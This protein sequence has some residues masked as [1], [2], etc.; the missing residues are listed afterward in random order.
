[1]C[2]SLNKIV[3]CFWNGK[4]A[5]EGWEKAVSLGSDTG[6]LEKPCDCRE[7]QTTRLPS[8]NKLAV[9]LLFEF[10]VWYPV[11]CFPWDCPTVA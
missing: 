7:G 10:G 1:M 4:K 6:I 11:L 8:P 5:T 9:P 2:L 3:G